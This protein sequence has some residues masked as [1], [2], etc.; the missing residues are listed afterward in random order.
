MEQ[1]SA[2]WKNFPPP[3]EKYPELGTGP[4]P[5]EPYISQRHFELE[6]D[7]IFRKTWLIVGRVE[8][9]PKA[10][11]YLAMDVEIAKSSIL[12]VRGEDGVVRGFYNQCS[13]R[14]SKV[15]RTG[16]GNCPVF[17]CPVHAWMY[18]LDGKL[19]SMPD[20]KGFFN[21]DKSQYG[22]TPL[23]TDIWGGFVFVN[24]DPEPTETLAEYLGDFGK[25][26]GDFPFEATGATMAE[27]RVELNCNWKIFKDAFQEPFHTTFVHQRT[28]GGMYA[29]P[30]NPFGYVADVKLY[31]R[32]HSVSQLGADKPIEPTGLMKIA[33]DFGPAEA[34]HAA[35]VQAN[36]DY[37][38]VHTPGTNPTKN[39]Y[40]DADLH[41]IFPN[42]ILNTF[43]GGRFFT[44]QIWPLAVDK[45]LWIARAYFP[46]PRNA[47]ERFSLEFNRVFL[48]DVVTEDGSTVEGMQKAITSGAKKVIPLHDQEIMVRHDRKV[49]EDH[50][51]F[52][53]QEA[54]NV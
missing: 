20:E 40:W 12:I 34:Q 15:A 3:H 31:P 2:H 49:I 41:G 38:A 23:A 52:Y 7:L 4:V 35:S 16:Q 30:S 6:R 37:K 26:V 43:A 44:N 10:G 14:S 50:V 27:W 9:V 11:D 39:P 54:A 25:D 5:L 47:G 42:L 28:L 29:N 46:K 19:R 8:E 17:R 24:F 51:G 18:S 32:H 53:K 13:H 21:L 22:L 36:T 45:S 1:S 48:R 33:R